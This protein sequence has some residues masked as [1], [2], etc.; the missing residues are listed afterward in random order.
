MEHLVFIGKIFLGLLAFFAVC[1]FLRDGYKHPF[2]P[3]C[4][5]S[6]CCERNEQGRAICRVHG[7]IT[8]IPIIEKFNGIE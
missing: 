2:C 1:I 6:V 8:D 5:D 7:D 3:K 4:G